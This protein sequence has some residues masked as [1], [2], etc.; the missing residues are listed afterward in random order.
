MKLS[1]LMSV[2]F[3][4]VLAFSLIACDNGNEPSKEVENP[5]DIEEFVK[6][7]TFYSSVTITRTTSTGSMVFAENENTCK[8]SYQVPYYA[9]DGTQDGMDV[10][11]INCNYQVNDGVITIT[12]TEEEFAGMELTIDNLKSD[13]TFTVDY[14]AALVAPEVLE[15][16]IE[17]LTLS[18]FLCTN[19]FVGK[20]WDEKQYTDEDGYREG[21]SV[22]ISGDSYS[23]GSLIQENMSLSHGGWIELDFISTSEV[24]INYDINASYTVSGNTATITVPG[25]IGTFTVTTDSKLNMS[26]EV[27]LKLLAFIYIDGKYYSNEVDLANDEY[28]LNPKV[29]EW[30][31]PLT[32]VQRW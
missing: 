29:D 5:S 24:T 15:F 12:T 30:N 27:F 31:T 16:G 17:T 18:Y 19:G 9:N 1:N 20:V 8:I 11:W 3:C 28:L 22:E 10:A 32:I 14:P 7:K 25:G 23:E 13:G 21:Y 26:D 4:V 2:I 6:G